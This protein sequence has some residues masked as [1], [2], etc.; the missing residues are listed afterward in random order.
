[1]SADRP[2]DPDGERLIETGSIGNRD[3]YQLLTSLVVPRPIGWVSTRSGG[4]SNLAPFSYYAALAATPMLVGISIGSRRDTPKDTL[5]NIRES[6]CFC[7]NVVTDALLA[8]MNQSA[9]EHPPEIDEFQVAGLTTAEASTV[10]APYVAGC[11][12]VLECRLFR[13][14]DLGDALNTLVIGEVLAVRLANELPLLPGTYLV[15]AGSLRPV[16]RLGG[17]LYAHL[18][19]LVALPRPRIE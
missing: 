19:E 5:R 8:A 9:G 3:R 15:D 10:D 13:E 2:Q 6:G 7:V 12:A 17:D 1:M 14:V 16:S 18:G 11:P 4:V